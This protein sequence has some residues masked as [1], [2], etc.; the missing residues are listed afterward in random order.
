MC[1]DFDPDD[2]GTSEPKPHLDLQSALVY[3]TREKTQEEKGQKRVLIV[4]SAGQADEEPT[5]KDLSKKENCIEP[6]CFA[7]RRL[8]TNEIDRASGD[9][10]PD[11]RFMVVVAGYTQEGNMWPKSNFG[12]VVE[13]GAPGGDERKE[14]GIL[15]FYAEKDQGSAHERQQPRYSYLW[16]TSQAAPHV[17]AAAALLLSLPKGE[18]NLPDADS[19][20]DINGAD[21]KQI[22]IQ[23]A[24]NGILDLRF[25]EGEKSP[26]TVVRQFV[27]VSKPTDQQVPY[28]LGVRAFLAGNYNEAVSRLTRA[29]EIHPDSADSSYF[30]ALALARIGDLDSADYHLR[31]ALR[32]DRAHHLENWGR[33]MEPLP[34]DLR[35]ALGK[36]RTNFFQ[37]G[38][39]PDSFP[40]LAAW[41]GQGPRPLG[42]ENGPFVSSSWAYPIRSPYPVMTSAPILYETRWPIA[43][44]ACL[45]RP[46]FSIRAMGYP[47]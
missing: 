40:F 4:C 41:S 45:V 8:F 7:D 31:R 23:S 38:D 46:V 42:L 19:E 12:K 11:P 16:G 35:V 20:R 22:I 6:A 27:R 33:L 43:S 37:T 17:A 36:V 44:G 9:P 32:L 25:L 21:V 26:P 5:G 28:E 2:A 29:V 47:R 14:K 24:K 3:A 15:S 1:F 34:G 13:I 10:F 39:L 18:L 30:L